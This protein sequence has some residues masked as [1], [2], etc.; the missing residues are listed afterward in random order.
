MQINKTIAAIDKHLPGWTWLIRSASENEFGFL[1][2]VMPPGFSYS[3]DAQSFKVW[4]GTVEVALS[5]A[6][7]AAVASLPQTPDREG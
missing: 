1:G 4:R 7:T 3:A 5:D 2:H 6:Y